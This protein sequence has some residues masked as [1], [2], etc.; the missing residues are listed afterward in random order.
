[1]I[2]VKKKY[3]KSQAGNAAIIVLVALVIAAVG[4]LAYLSGKMTSE[5]TAGAGSTVATEVAA[6]DENAQGEQ[7]GAEG[8]KIV[9]EP[10]NPVV[11]KLDEQEISRLDVFNFIQTLPPSTRQ[12]PIDQLFPLAV[13]EVVNARVISQKVEDVNLDNHPKVK[14]QLAAAKKTIVRSVFIENAV[15]EKMTEERLQQAYQAYS[16]GFPDI[17][18]AKASHILVDDEGLAKDLIKKLNEGADFATL[19]KENSKDG[20]AEK[21]G[22]IGYFAQNEVVPE[23]AEA[24]FALN[25]DDYTSKPV[26]S[27]FG[28]HIIKL[29]EKRKRPTPPYEQVKPFL[30][31]QLRQAVL[32]EVI[33]GWRDA[34]KIE[35]FD[36]N[37]KPI[38]AAEPAA[39]E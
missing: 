9:I 23:F 13:N 30:E 22:Q 33:D 15:D 8:T 1:M 21:G 36:I 17:D 32:V 10:G 37:G 3:Q 5:E 27:E 26:E 25:V 28:F 4:G 11:A 19:A 7:A 2:D 34:A 24:A 6:G 16:N 29:E 12:M 20:T 39:G 35:T 18:E 38:E 14:E 31:G